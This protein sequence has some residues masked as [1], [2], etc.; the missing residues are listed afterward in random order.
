MSFYG[1]RFYSPGQGRFLNR[2]PINEPGSRLLRDVLKEGDI[3][4]ELNLYAF[5]G[6]NPMNTWDYLGLSENGDDEG[7]CGTGWNEDIVPDAPG[8]YDFSSC[9][10]EHDDCYGD[11]DGPSKKVCDDDFFDCMMNVCIDEYSG[12]QGCS[13]WAQIYYGAVNNHGQ[14][15]FDNAREDCC[16]D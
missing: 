1:F 9:C 6:N 14:D 12:S 15:P 11:C 10:E 4:E 2:D 7:A 13:G 8:G 3:N 16:D 5:V